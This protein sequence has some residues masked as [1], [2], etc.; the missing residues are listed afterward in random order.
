MTPNNPM[1][2]AGPAQEPSARWAFS[3]W[4]WQLMSSALPTAVLTAFLSL[5]ASDTGQQR[6]G[7]IFEDDGHDVWKT[8][9][10]MNPDWTLTWN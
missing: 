7:R 9:L 4:T 8:K 6:V 10:D 3:G 2:H 1:A 5:G